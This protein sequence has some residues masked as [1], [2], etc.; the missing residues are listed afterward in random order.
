MTPGVYELIF[1][2]KTKTYWLLLYF[3]FFSS[4]KLIIIKDTMKLL[5]ES[6]KEKM[7]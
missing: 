1:S 3:L 2:T 4:I 5:K 6:N 7:L